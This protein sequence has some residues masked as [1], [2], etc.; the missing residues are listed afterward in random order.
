MTDIEHKDDTKN[1]DRKYEKLLTKISELEA[2]N[3]KVS[4]IN[5]RLESQNQQMWEQLRSMN[6][7]GGVSRQIPEEIAAHVKN[8]ISDSK[9]SEFQK[10]FQQNTISVNDKLLL[11][12]GDHDACGMY[13][14]KEDTKYSLLQYAARMGK[15]E[16]CS[17]LL[18]L[19]AVI[20]EDEVNKLEN[21]LRENSSMHILILLQSATIQ[22]AGGTEVEDNVSR[23]HR[24]TGVLKCFLNILSKNENMKMFIDIMETI[25]I[26]S[27]EN[28]N[29]FSDDFLNLL[30]HYYVTIEK[31]SFNETKLWEV[32]K[33][34]CIHVIKNKN[35]KNWFWF[36][37]YI[38]NSTIFLRK[39]DKNV[40]FFELLNIVNDGLEDVVNTKLRQPF[41]QIAQKTPD[42]WKELCSYDTET[43][44]E[45]KCRQDSIPN[46]M[47]PD[48]SV[49]E[50]T[51]YVPGSTTF[52]AHKH[53]D[54]NEYLS[55]LLLT[56]H[57][58]DKEFHESIK[59]IFDID[60]ETDKSKITELNDMEYQ[61]G[62]V[63]LINRMKAKAE[64]DYA[65]E[66]FPSS[67]CILD[68]NRCALVF[69]DISSM[70][71]GLDLIKNKISYFKSGNIIGI[72]RAKN[73][74]KEYSHKTPD[75]AD[76]KFN[77]L[78]KGVKYNVVGEVQFMLKEMMNFKH[79][80]HSLYSIIRRKEFVTDF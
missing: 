62:P 39:G 48:Y 34:K 79:S 17:L 70:L 36:K 7:S 10:L 73:G 56:A 40:L 35:M 49:A 8:C 5:I 22:S 80:A 6:K 55:K 29:G 13:V 58:V 16:I 44:L 45:S 14:L 26:Q 59:Q 11:K 18:N 47:K 3:Q 28:E 50:L 21:T 42:D 52:N 64:T 63:K 15:Y 72:C 43:I 24:Q 9:I 53:Y 1:D 32:I 57:T 20:T 19:G 54:I 25:I 41:L 78:I 61:R 67:A 37:N 33:N 23:L 77:V 74:F 4:T 38:I 69:E 65:N 71:K 66:P 46:G 76:I 2:E 27:I 31:K 51:Q 30:Y 75:Y 12:K 68:M 60:L